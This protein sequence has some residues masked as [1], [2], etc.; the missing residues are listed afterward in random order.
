MLN[1][2]RGEQMPIKNYSTKIGVERTISQIEKILALHGAKAI[3]KEYDGVGR[4]TALNFIVDFLEGQS[5]PFRMPLDVQA[6]MEKINYDI[7]NPQ[8]REGRIPST[9]KN[10]MEYARRVGWRIIKDWIDAQM[11]LVD[12]KQAKIIQ[13]F[14][15]YAYNALNK[16]TFYEVLEENNFKSLP[17]LEG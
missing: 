15:P 12:L 4:V 8:K 16:K 17:L 2:G 6:L 9:R 5:I 14:L 1:C 13:V 3:M 11:A 10:D 7:D